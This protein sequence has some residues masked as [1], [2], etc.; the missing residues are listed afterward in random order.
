MLNTHICT[1]VPWPLQRFLFA[2][3]GSFPVAALRNYRFIFPLTNVKEKVPTQ[4]DFS[5][6][7]RRILLPLSRKEVTRQSPR[8]NSFRS[9]NRGQERTI[10]KNKRTNKQTRPETTE[11]H[12][13]IKCLLEQTAP[14]GGNPRYFE[15]LLQH[16]PRGE[17]EPPRLLPLPLLLL[18]RPSQ[19]PRKAAEG[20]GG[21]DSSN[22]S[23]R[24]QLPRPPQLWLLR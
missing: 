13:A 19:R 16:Q 11:V 14:V 4:R 6:A 7:R 12:T 18:R 23:Y 9:V 22:T 2:I 10:H 21:R 17:G 1:L 5:E 15:P 20:S 3:F 8:R 24:H